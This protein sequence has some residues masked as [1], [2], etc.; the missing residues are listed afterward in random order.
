MLVQYYSFLA[1][2]KGVENLL[3]NNKGKIDHIITSIE[4]KEEYNIYFIKLRE[5]NST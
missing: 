3:N 2:Q 5:V 4:I 1:I